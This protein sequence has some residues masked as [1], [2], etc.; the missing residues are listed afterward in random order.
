MDPAE[1]HFRTHPEPSVGGAYQH[2]FE[3]LKTNFLELLLIIIIAI[4]FF[5]PVGIAEAV[6]ET[7]GEIAWTA[8]VFSFVYGILLGIPLDYGIA[9]A[10]LK[11]ARGEK[12]ETRDLFQPFNNWLNVIGAGIL[13]GV[14]IGFG[15]LLLIIPGIIFACKLALVPYL[16]M[17]KNL[18]PVA[19]IKTSWEM[20]NGHGLTIFVM[21]LLAIPIAILG[22]VLLLVGIVPASMW[23][24]GAFASIYQAINVRREANLSIS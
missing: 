3:S 18:D 16:V 11:A 22:L 1:Q 12:V 13:S 9:W 23:I 10:F 4:V 2:S 20:T 15:F 14:I 24:E 21:Y 8:G 5:I 7:R 17:D 6:M 19:A